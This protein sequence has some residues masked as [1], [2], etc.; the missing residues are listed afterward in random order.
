MHVVIGYMLTAPW[1][2][3]GACVGESRHMLDIDGG[4]ERG[5]NGRVVAYGGE[6]E[7]DGEEGWVLAWRLAL[8]VFETLDLIRT[9]LTRSASRESATSG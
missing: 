6:A 9:L 2:F 5:R 3:G 7:R 1:G 8:R 4:R